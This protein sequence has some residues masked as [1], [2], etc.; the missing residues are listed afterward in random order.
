MRGAFCP[1]LIFLQNGEFQMKLVLS[2]LLGAILCASFCHAAKQS[3]PFVVLNSSNIAQQIQAS[4]LLLVN[5][6]TKRCPCSKTLDSYLIN[7]IAK[8]P[9]ITFA[10]VN[11]DSEPQ[12]LTQYRVAKLPTLLFFK[13]GKLV[14]RLADVPTEAAL[15]AKLQEFL[16]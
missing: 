13:N 7:A 16:K 14:L 1:V 2:L 10:K 6:A 15:D 5:V 8:F 9:Q 4:S 3:E 12:V 11:G